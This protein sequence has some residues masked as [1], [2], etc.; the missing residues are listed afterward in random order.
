MLEIW[1]KFNW[2]SMQSRKPSTQPSGCVCI[3][4][5]QITYQRM[6]WLA[7][8]TSWRHLKQ[9]YPTLRRV[10]AVAL[11]ISLR[12]SQCAHSMGVSV[13]TVRTVDFSFR[14]ALNREQSRSHPTSRP[15]VR[16]GR[17]PIKRDD[18]L[19]PGVLE[20]QGRVVKGKAQPK[21]EVAGLVEI[22]EA[23][24]LLNSSVGHFDT[25]DSRFL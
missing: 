19:L 13:N 8:A 6:Q 7:F 21:P 12:R 22:Y 1:V 11:E 10:S 5:N 14:F 25:H 17:V 4:K 9:K 2:G 23:C 15:L 18:F 16:L 20:K 24:H 3:S